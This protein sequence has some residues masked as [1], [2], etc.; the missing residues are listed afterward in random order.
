HLMPADRQA[1]LPPASLQVS[2]YGHSATPAPVHASTTW[3]IRRGDATYAAPL[4]KLTSPSNLTSLAI[5]FG[6]LEFGETYFWKCIHTD[7]NGHPSL[8]SVESSFVFGGESVTLP[9]LALD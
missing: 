6:A 1:I 5:P 2:A 9:L 8:E 7:S 3:F 4:I